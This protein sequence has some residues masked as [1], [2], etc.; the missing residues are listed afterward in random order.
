MDSLHQAP[1][2]IGSY[3]WVRVLV[4]ITHLAQILLT[5]QVGQQ[6]LHEHVLLLLELQRPELHQAAVLGALIPA[7]ASRALVALSS[8]S[9][10]LQGPSVLPVRLAPADAHRRRLADLEV[11]AAGLVQQQ[12]FPAVQ[13]LSV[14]LEEVLSP[15]SVQPAELWWQVH[16]G[17]DS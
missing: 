7:S 15:R 11:V 14:V 5:K 16:V 1:L 9:P 8:S 4:K 13:L 12:S 2:D 3:Y 6:S 17:V 10:A